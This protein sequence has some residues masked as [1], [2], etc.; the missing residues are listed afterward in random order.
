[1]IRQRT[2]DVCTGTKPEAALNVAE[3]ELIR[4]V[5]SDQRGPEVTREQQLSICNDGLE[6]E[7]QQRN[8]PMGR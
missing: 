1:M 4:S 6:V 8:D 5:R 3:H 7:E 2:I